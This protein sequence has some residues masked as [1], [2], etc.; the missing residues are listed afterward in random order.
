VFVL[1]SRFEGLPLVVMDAFALGVPVVATAGS[2][3]SE[4]VTD[5]VTGLLSPVGDVAALAESMRRVL[6]DPALAAQLRRGALV[7]ALEYSIE[8]TAERTLTVYERV[9]AR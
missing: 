6:T 5:G 4:L 9:L 8:R 7:R 3:V 1:S 2:G